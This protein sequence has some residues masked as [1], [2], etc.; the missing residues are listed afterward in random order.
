MNT[1]IRRTIAVNSGGSASCDG[2]F[3]I[4]MNAFA[5]GALGGNPQSFL[6]TPGNTVDAQWWGRDTPATGAFLSDA[7]EWNVVP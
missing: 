3:A 2:E 6:V 7:V 1:P 4:D 5:A